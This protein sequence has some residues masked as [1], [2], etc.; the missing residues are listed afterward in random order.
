[1]AIRFRRSLIGYY[2]L[3]VIN[4]IALLK[5]A[6]ENDISTLDRE[7]LVEE[8]KNNDI[9]NK[10][11]HIKNEIAAIEEV[12]KKIAAQLSAAHINGAERIN[13][14]K[15]RAK[16]DEDE[17][18]EALLLNEKQNRDLGKVINEL[19]MELHSKVAE[20]RKKFETFNV[21]EED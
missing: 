4:A 2:P 17:L 5:Q 1:M 6:F 11:S 9:K 20:Y 8:N 21:S 15:E 3:G 18:I 13:K 19:T 10:I 7:L 14:I 16:K 12:E